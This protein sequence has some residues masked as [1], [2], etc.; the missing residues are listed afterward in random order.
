MFKVFHFFTSHQIS[1]SLTSAVPSRPP[2]P[3]EALSMFHTTGLAAALLV[4][5]LANPAMA[6]I[7]TYGATLSG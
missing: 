2:K 5:G 1:A 6:D 4:L 3:H 7:I